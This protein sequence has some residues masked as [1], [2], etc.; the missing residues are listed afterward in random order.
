MLHPALPCSLFPAGQWYGALYHT[1]A[2]GKGFLPTK[3]ARY[4]DQC[5]QKSV[6]FLLIPIELN[7]EKR[8]VGQR[9]AIFLYHG[10]L[11]LADSFQ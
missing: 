7:Q 4:G 3:A 11:Q 2:R 8:T 10:F 5:I 1:T 9:L 6:Q